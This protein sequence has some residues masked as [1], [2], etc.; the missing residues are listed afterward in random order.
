MEPA[1]ADAP[2]FHRFPYMT[3]VLLW[4][5][6]F[7][8]LAVLFFD[9][10]SYERLVLGPKLETLIFF[11]AKQNGLIANWEF[12]RLFAPMFLHANLIHLG[13]NMYAFTQVGRFMEIMFGPRYL[14]ITY[15]VGGIVGNIFSFAFIPSLGKSF[16]IFGSGQGHALLSVGASGSLFAIFLFLFVLQKYQVRLARETGI[17]EPRTNLGPLIVVNG[18]ITFLVPNIDWACHLGGAVGGAVL[19]L[20]LSLHHAH[21]RRKYASVKFMAFGDTI[22]NPKFWLK[23]AT[24]YWG[25]V[26][27]CVL[28][29][30]NLLRVTKAEK[31][32]GVGLLAAAN[33]R[34]DERDV[35]YISQFE[36]VLV[37]RKSETDP[38]N[39][40]QGALALHA[41]GHYGAAQKVY[42]VLSFFHRQKVGT[43]DFLAPS[44]AGVLAGAFEAASRGEPFVKANSSVGT[45]VPGVEFC[46]KPAATFRNLGFQLLAGLLWECAYEMDT[47]S[48]KYAASAVEAYWRS[49]RQQLL[50]EFLH[51]VDS[52][53]VNALRLSPTPLP[54]PALPTQPSPA[55]APAPAL[56]RELELDTNEPIPQGEEI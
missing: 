2:H 40:L 41:A 5:N 20:G 51:R 31:V 9:G 38:S 14:V 54:S 6:I 52:P 3:Y 27:L 32:L 42:L 28:L 21:L 26:A 13:F 55:P 8:F 16:Q 24:W 36:N 7:V 25:L 39:M 46:A 11:G 4:I 53:G 30:G 35:E 50:F 12:E 19:G 23:P 44:T 18:F 22:P 48:D 43:A 37:H 10:I 34:L 33:E 47:K 17:E 29:M 49:E 45:S 1:S 56:P 15:V